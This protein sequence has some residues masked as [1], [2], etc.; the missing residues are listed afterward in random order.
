MLHGIIARM[1]ETQGVLPFESPGAAAG[2][3]PW[4]VRRSARA[5][6]LALR[7][8]LDGRVEVV[9]PRGVAEVTVRAF[10]SR[11]L[12]W[13]RR[14]LA[15]RAQ[16]KIPEPFP[17]AL[18][19]LPALGQRF[20]VHLAG[21]RGRPRPRLLADGVLSLCGDWSADMVLSRRALLSWL[22]DHVHGVVEPQLR[23]LAVAGGFR[24]DTLQLRRQR[25]RWGS[26]SARGVISLNVCAVF[27]S[28]AVL[29]YLMIHELSHTRHMNHSP[30]FWRTVEG[31]CPD[32]RL[33][34]RELSLGWRRVPSWLFR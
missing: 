4:L 27:Q 14:K 28:P 20:R 29:R 34:D 33:L 32:Y 18:L 10:M 12:D 6:R 1:T 2:E 24:F 22:I 16:P 21:G 30:D 3:A 15:A 19:D 13:V 7:V 5:R 31:H 9:V 17:P 8:H 25:S 26:C 11:H 23:E